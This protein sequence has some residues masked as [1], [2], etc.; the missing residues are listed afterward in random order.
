MCSL[1]RGVFPQSDQSCAYHGGLLCGAP[2][3][4]Q[5][6]VP[7]DD[8]RD[9]LC[10][11]NHGVPRDDLCGAPLYVQRGVARDD[12]RGALCCVHHGVPRDAQL[13]AFLFNLHDF[14]ACPHS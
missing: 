9:A 5:R 7:R 4:V 14:P 6:D 12:L 11:V 13:G 8:L 1:P 3:D 10:C 2:L